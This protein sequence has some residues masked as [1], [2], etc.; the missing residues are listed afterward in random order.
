MIDAGVND[1]DILIVDKSN[2][3]PTEKQ[4]AVCELNGEYTVKRVKEIAGQ[5]WLV[6]ANPEYPN[7]RLNDEDSFSVW[8][9]VTYIIS[10]PKY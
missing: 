9:V 2:R 6:P 3:Q 8:G 4:I 5:R 10:K 7:I 1:G